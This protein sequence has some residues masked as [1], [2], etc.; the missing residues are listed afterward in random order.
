MKPV[1][2]ILLTYN[3]ERHIARA[4]RSVASFAQE[5]VVVDSYSTDRTVELARADGAL[6]VQHPFVT[7]AQQ[8]QWALDNVPV[9]S[10]WVMRLD[11]DETIEPA[12]A[13]EIVRDLPL[14]P[15]DVVG[16]NLRRKHIFLGRWIRHGGR[17]P[18]ILLRLWRRGQGRVEDRWM[19][20]HMTVRGGRTVTFRGDFQDCNLGDLSAFTDKHN[21]YAT[22]EAID[23]VIQRWQLFPDESA[24]TAAESSGQ[25]ALKRALKV[26]LYNRL[27]FEFSA[28]L[29]FLWRYVVRLGFLDGRE[30]FV[31][32][33]LQAYWYRVLIG[34]KVLEFNRALTGLDNAE[35]RL[36]ALGKLTGY[37]FGQRAQ[38]R[39]DVA[40][41]AD[42][43][44]QSSA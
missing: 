21:R 5:I 23:V 30:G 34:A 4:L 26:Q 36:Q 37:R 13:A 25:A 18:L 43:R 24:L 32:H 29:Y 40:L 10:P 11:A 22:R 39:T 14:L 35:Q 12:L 27:P 38:R 44:S 20:E 7:Q 2:V 9:S 8:F 17:Y 16:V 6:V 19:D 3:E 28:A 1:A 42:A 33:F 15:A 41:S 31:Y